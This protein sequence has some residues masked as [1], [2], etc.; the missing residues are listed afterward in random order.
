MGH[1]PPPGSAGFGIV[2]CH[3][4]CGSASSRAAL[5]DIF[6]PGGITESI[7]PQMPGILI[8]LG[9]AIL[10]QQIPLPKAGKHL[11]E[12]GLFFPQEEL[13]EGEGAGK[14]CWSISAG[15]KPNPWNTQKNYQQ[16]QTRRCW[17]ELR[18]CRHTQKQVR[19][20]EGCDLRDL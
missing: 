19:H 3:A 8:A 17:P 5:G 9:A 15:A 11:W 14:E 18:W 20:E 12:N 4:P 6:I 10:S 7:S 16:E 2:Y 1:T 13:A